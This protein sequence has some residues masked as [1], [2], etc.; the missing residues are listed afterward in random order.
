[1]NQH[2]HTVKHTHTGP[3]PEP[4][5]RDETGSPGR[6]FGRVGS[7]HGSVCRT[8]HLTRFWVLTCAFIA[9]LFLH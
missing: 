7:G 5:Y 3:I 8:R 4:L 2:T 9:A 6:D 1:M